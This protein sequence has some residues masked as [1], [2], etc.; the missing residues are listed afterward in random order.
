MNRKIKH[1]GIIESIGK[2]FIRV[3]IIENYAC[4]ECSVASH[5][6]ASDMKE[7]IVN[8]YNLNNIKDYR[9]DETVIVTASTKIE[10]NAILL[11]FII[12]FIIMVVTLFIVASTTSDELL[13]AIASLFVLVPYYVVLYYNRGRIREKLSFEIER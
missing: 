3:R 11:A 6:N 7:K 1:S 12:P 9:I 13:S 10:F 5:C 8:I 4:S 2:D